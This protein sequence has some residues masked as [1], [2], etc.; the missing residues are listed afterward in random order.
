MYKEL[1]T[2]NKL[3]WLEH[4]RE[5]HRLHLILSEEQ[6]QVVFRGDYEEKRVDLKVSRLIFDYSLTFSEFI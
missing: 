1:K 5:K 6:L 3:L 4:F 2:S